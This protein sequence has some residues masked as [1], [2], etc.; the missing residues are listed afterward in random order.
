MYIK[1]IYQVCKIYV[2]IYAKF[3]VYAYYAY[4][5]STINRT[6]NKIRTMEMQTGATKYSSSIPAGPD[7]Y[8]ITSGF[9]SIRIDSE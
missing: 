8:A 3:G 7:S 6:M 5:I 4:L 9:A 2:K 1:L